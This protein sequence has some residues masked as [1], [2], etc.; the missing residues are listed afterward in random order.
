[1]IRVVNQ[2][3]GEIIFFIS[4]ATT[5]HARTGQ[6]HASEALSSGRIRF[7]QSVFMD[8]LL[9]IYFPKAVNDRFLLATRGTVHH[10]LFTA[11]VQSSFE[12]QEFHRNVI[13]NFTRI[14]SKTLEKH[15]IQEIFLYFKGAQLHQ[16]KPTEQHGYSNWYDT[17][18]A[19][20]PA[21]AC[22]RVYIENLLWFLLFCLFRLKRPLNM[23]AC[24]C[25][26]SLKKT[27]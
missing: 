8:S 26:V 20:P 14:N 25:Y 1:M 18:G 19:M 16:L 11:T 12:M 9:Y 22:L 13:R 10:Q 17:S 3:D 5:L 4:I 24:T 23:N 27:C 2:I 7:L 15:R 6:E 21:M